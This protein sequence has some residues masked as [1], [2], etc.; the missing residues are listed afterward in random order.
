VRLVGYLKR[1]VSMHPV[2]FQVREV[3]FPTDVFTLSSD[4]LLFIT[5]AAN[6]SHKD[7]KITTNKRQAMYV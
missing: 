5:N 1:Y 6:E 4:P 3:L 2:L 7:V